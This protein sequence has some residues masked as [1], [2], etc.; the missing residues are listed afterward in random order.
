MLQRLAEGYTLVLAGHGRVRATAYNKK[1]LARSDTEATSQLVALYKAQVAISQKRS[2]RAQCGPFPEYRLI[3][4]ET[5]ASDTI[6]S[7]RALAQ[8][9]CHPSAN[10]D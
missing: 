7:P 6:F 10:V 8:R 3:S 4:S 5:L 2:S 1:Q 9:Y